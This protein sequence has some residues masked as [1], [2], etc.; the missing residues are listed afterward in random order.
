MQIGAAFFVISIFG[1]GSDCFAEETNRRKV[2]L[3]TVD[4]RGTSCGVASALAR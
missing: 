2:S 1:T 4:F 3:G